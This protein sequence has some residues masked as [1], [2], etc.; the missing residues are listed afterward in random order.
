MAGGYSSPVTTNGVYG[1][2]KARGRRSEPRARAGFRRGCPVLLGRRRW[3][4]SCRVGANRHHLS[5]PPG[6]EV[7]KGRENVRRWQ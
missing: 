4:P 6:A 1:G 3:G 2:P 7:S 5:N